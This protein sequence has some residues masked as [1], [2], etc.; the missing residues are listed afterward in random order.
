MILPKL[1]EV[2]PRRP[3]ERCCDPDAIPSMSLAETG[4]ATADL[5]ILAHPVRMQ[6]L[7]VL[8]R[9]EGSVCV[10]DLEAALPVKQPTV[11]HHL[12]LLRKAGLIQSERRGLYAY[13][14]VDR[15]ALDALRGR[16]DRYLAKFG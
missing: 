6:L 3:G 11:S 14:R 16:I 4:L 10:C 2:A 9:K 5:E 7:D 15:P 8:A 13:Y 1:E 12:K